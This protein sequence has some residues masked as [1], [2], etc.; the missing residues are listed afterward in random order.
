M[1][2]DN[3][4]HIIVTIQLGQASVNPQDLCLKWGGGDVWRMHR[5]HSEQVEHLPPVPRAPLS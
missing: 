2:C 1:C 4:H 3:L 5:W